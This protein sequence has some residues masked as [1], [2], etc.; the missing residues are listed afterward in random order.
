MMPQCWNSHGSERSKICGRLGGRGRRYTLVERKAEL[1][2][3]LA[4]GVQV[5]PLHPVCTHL[6]PLNENHASSRAGV[7]FRQ[8]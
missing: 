2:H 7:V 6:H 5:A 8:K 4:K 1:C 3:V